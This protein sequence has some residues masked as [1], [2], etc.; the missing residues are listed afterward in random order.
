MIGVSLIVSSLVLR[1]CR[2]NRVRVQLKMVLRISH[3]VGSAGTSQTTIPGLRSVEVA[4]V[5]LSF[6]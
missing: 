1:M 6:Y 4:P 2:G 3:H 5:F